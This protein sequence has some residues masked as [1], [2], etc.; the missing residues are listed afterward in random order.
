M[1]KWKE[2][3][4]KEELLKNINMVDAASGNLVWDMENGEVTIDFSNGLS[5]SAKI[6]NWEIEIDPDAELYDP[7]K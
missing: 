5:C 6:I 7:T 2:I 4:N 3:Q 1:T